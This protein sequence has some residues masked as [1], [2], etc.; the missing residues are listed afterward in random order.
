[1]RVKLLLFAFVLCTASAFSQLVTFE[2]SGSV[3][4]IFTDGEGIIPDISVGES[5]SGQFSYDDSAEGTPYGSSIQYNQT[6][7]A[8]ISI[9]EIFISYNSQP[10]EIYVDNDLYAIRE[11]RNEDH[12]KYQ[13]NTLISEFESDNI[14]CRIGFSD[15]TASAFDSFDLPVSFNL[16]EF[17]IAKLT[18]FRDTPRYKVTAQIDEIT[19]VPEPCTLAMLALGGVLIRKRRGGEMK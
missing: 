16:T 9:G 15:Y 12:F 18:I 6:A 8:Q 13:F 11:D 17:D 1:M 14:Y 5:F 2:F 7:S 4:E 10:V 19:L 3:S